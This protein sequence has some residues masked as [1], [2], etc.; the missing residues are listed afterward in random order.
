MVKYN[1]SCYYCR[2]PHSLSDLSHF[3][4]IDPA[5]PE[6]SD[7]APICVYCVQQMCE[8]AIGFDE[9]E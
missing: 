2:E 9:D 3:D 8:A 5:D 4:P 1:F 6:Y 7:V